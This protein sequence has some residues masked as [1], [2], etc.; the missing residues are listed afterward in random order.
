MGIVSVLIAAIT[1]YAFGAV[2]YMV[3]AK[4]WMAASGVTQEQ[5]RDGSKMPF[6]ISGVMV[7][8]VAGM[9]RH[10]FVQ[11]GIDD[12]NKGLITGFGLGAFIAAPWIVTNYAY[13]MRPR[14]LTVID[15]GYA[16]IG[17]TLMGLV[18]GFFAGGSAAG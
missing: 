12:L 18:L 17:C 3:L 11:A 1:A 2:Y 14:M 8:L 9:M 10:I 15:G 7:I 5:A 6:V 16:T 13:G 4:P